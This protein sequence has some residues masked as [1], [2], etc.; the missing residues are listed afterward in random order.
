MNDV[1]HLTEV[2]HIEVGKNDEYLFF[3]GHVLHHNNTVKVIWRLSSLTEGGIIQVPLR[4]LFQ[5]QAGT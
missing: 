4:A 1:K 5:A 2:T 3:F